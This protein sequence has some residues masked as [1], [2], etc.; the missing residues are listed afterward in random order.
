VWAKTAHQGFD[1]EGAELDLMESLMDRGLPGLRRPYAG[2]THQRQLP[3]EAESGPRDRK[4]PV[5]LT[6]TGFRPCRPPCA[7][8]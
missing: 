4:V 5:V 8:R 2:E 6:L 1:I 7:K 3:A